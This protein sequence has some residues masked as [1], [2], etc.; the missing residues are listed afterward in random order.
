MDVPVKTEE[1][2]FY[3]SS[4]MGT[5]QISFQVGYFN[6][7]FCLSEVIRFLEVGHDQYVTKLLNSKTLSHLKF[8]TLSQP[9]I[10]PQF[11]FMSQPII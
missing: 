10:L 4:K 11:L 7:L 6:F 9:S 5:E 1:Q 2:K 8:I 3:T